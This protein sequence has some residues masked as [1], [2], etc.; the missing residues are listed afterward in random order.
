MFILLIFVLISYQGIFDTSFFD[1]YLGTDFQSLF[2]KMV[3]EEQNCVYDLVGYQLFVL[4][5]SQVVTKIAVELLK[6]FFNKLVFQ[7]LL[8][9]QQWRPDILSSLSVHCVWLLYTKSIQWLILINMPYFIVASLFIDIVMFYF[10]HFVFKNFY[11]KAPN[12]SE[13]A[14]FLVKMLNF[15]FWFNIAFLLLWYIFPRTHACGPI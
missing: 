6:A 14:S 11:A 13:I 3:T 8:R 4:V 5:I 15:T 7:I 2:K 1:L 12:S 10:M 9:K